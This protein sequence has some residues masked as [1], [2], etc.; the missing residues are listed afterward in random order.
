MEPVEEINYT[1][2]LDASKEDAVNQLFSFSKSEK[3]NIEYGYHA[4][5]ASLSVSSSAAGFPNAAASANTFVIAVIGDKAISQLGEHVDS[6]A[7]SPNYGIHEI[8]LDKHQRKYIGVAGEG[9]S[10]TNVGLVVDIKCKLD[11]DKIEEWQ[12]R[13]FNQIIMYIIRQKVS[14]N[15]RFLSHR[16]SGILNQNNIASGNDTGSH[17]QN[18]APDGMYASDG[19]IQSS[20][21]ACKY[22]TVLGYNTSF[23]NSDLL[24]RHRQLLLQVQVSLLWPRLWAG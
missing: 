15:K 17:V 4:E 22:C 1:V 19:I 14:M 5:H 13:T 6:R 12:I 9:T 23:N 10:Y 7:Q 24:E 21:T 18:Q 16:P 3:V 2:V 20:K 11:R 8:D